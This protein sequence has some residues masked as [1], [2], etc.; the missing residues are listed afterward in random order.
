[1]CIIGKAKIRGITK[2]SK[3][4]LPIQKVCL[5]IN[6]VRFGKNLMV[7]GKLKVY[8]QGHVIL[9]SNVTINSADWAN[10]IGGWNHTYFQVG[11]VL[12]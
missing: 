12:S 3:L 11:G 4:I 7:R 5:M 10:P 9:G 8:N 1:M 6:G 2:W